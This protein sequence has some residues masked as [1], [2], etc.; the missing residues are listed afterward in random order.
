[1]IA[2]VTILLLSVLRFLRVTGTL[3][4]WG[5]TLALVSG[6]LVIT[7]FVV[8]EGAKIAP[9]GFAN[10]SKKSISVMEPFEKV[11]ETVPRVVSKNHWKLKETDI[12]K[13]HFEAK[14]GMSL[15]TFSSTM[16]IDISSADRRSANIHVL[17]GTRSL[18]DPGH[19][20]K[21]IAKF[22]SGLGSALGDSKELR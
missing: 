20:D 5:Y 22:L 6:V 21:M 15:H 19:N 16:L 10:V 14:I 8:W 3:S 12:K 13:G 7:S 17:C 11:C 4:F 2:V 9:T 1:M 18:H